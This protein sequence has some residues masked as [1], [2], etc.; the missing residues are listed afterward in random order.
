[1]AERYW[2]I[3]DASGR[4][5][6]GGSYQYDLPKNGKPGKWTPRIADPKACVRGYHVC[7]DV[8]LV[9]WCTSWTTIWLVEVRGQVGE[10]ETKVVAES[11][12]LVAPT[13]WDAT[14]D[15]LC[16]VECVADVQ[17][18]LTD[19]RALNA[20]EVAYRHALG[21][22]T[23]DELAAA[24]AAAHAARDEWGTDKASAIA[25]SAAGATTG[26]VASLAA[27]HAATDAAAW[28]V[29]RASADPRDAGWVT[30]WS[31]A[32]A[33]AGAR[34]TQRLLWWIGATTDYPQ[35]DVHHA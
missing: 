17:H 8:D 3:L 28:D 12:R 13:P 21:D 5:C 22:A 31:A 26:V 4:A 19:A 7:R 9:Q 16:A 14:I 10:V 20:L 2:K 35:E 32:W 23:D 11:I 18:L 29:A 1:M 34:H 24:H 30:A 27:A 25:S 33:A 6:H 15:R